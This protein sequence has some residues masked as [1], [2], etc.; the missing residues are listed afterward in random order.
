MMLFRMIIAIVLVTGLAACA[1]APR[2]VKIA[3]T[4]QDGILDRFDRCPA[5]PAGV[6]VDA[7]G[8]PHDSDRDGVFDYRDD[9]PGSPA[10]ELVTVR[11]CPVD[12]DGDGVADHL[13]RC[14][15]TPTGVAVD[16]DGCPRKL[17]ETPIPEPVVQPPRQLE[18]RITFRTGRAVL[19][20]EFAKEFD[21][22]A[23]F[24]RS[25]P[26]CTVTIEGHTDNVGPARYNRKLSLQRA[27]VVRKA[28][29]ARL[30]AGIR[31]QVA[32]YG[33]ERP[34][35]DNRTQEGRSRN[36]RVLIS[37]NEPQQASAQ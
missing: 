26:N 23:A 31:M 19:E 12:E 2:E 36:R 10:D 21:E 13:D 35:A 6:P 16:A 27:E 9:C 29:Q 24:I 18:L 17:V 14:P 5:T 4:D 28:L 3:D 37:I 22:G 15:Q 11:G 32:G 30:G 1:A 7:F 8:C 34:I 25:C 20:H 33:E